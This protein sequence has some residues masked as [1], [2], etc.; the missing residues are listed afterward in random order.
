MNHRRRVS[1]ALAV[2]LL[3]AFAAGTTTEILR[4]SLLFQWHV[5]VGDSFIFT[6]HVTGNATSG[7]VVL[8]S[9][10]ASMNNTMIRSEIVDLPNIS[11]F[12]RLANFMDEVVKFPKTSSEFENGSAIPIQHRSQINGLVSRCLLPV[13]S[14]ALLDSFYPDRVEMPQNVTEVETYIGSDLGGIFRIGFARISTNQASGW[15]G[16]LDKS[17]GVPL[18]MELWAWSNVSP[19]RYSYNVTLIL[20]V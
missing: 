14:W 9:P 4:N 10:F 2:T 17:T 19:Y 16:Q 6:V 11:I 1:L 3:A 15:H 18:W 5:Q 7:G 12:M 13:G 8:D 20:N